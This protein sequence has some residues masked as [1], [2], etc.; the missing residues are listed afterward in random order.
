MEQAKITPDDRILE[1][2]PGTGV[3]TWSLVQTKA[4]V[5]L[6]EIEAAFIN[7]LSER[8]LDCDQTQI[9]QADA[10]AWIEDDEN[11]N[12]TQFNK[13][14]SNIP[15]S[16]SSPLITNLAFH[17]FRLQS[18]VLLVQKEVAERVVAPVNSSQRGVLSLLAQEV[19]DVK[20]AGIVPATAF[21]PKP[22]ID[23]AILVLS[24]KQDGNLH[25]LE[26]FFLF[27]KI[28]FKHRRK[29]VYNN[30]RS[31]LKSSCEDLP[32]NIQL[33]MKKRPQNLTG[34]DIRNLM[35]QVQ[36]K[37]GDTHV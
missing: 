36:M 8:L 5:I 16:I 7:L 12:S 17:A 19:F 11:W 35:E 9:I 26:Q 6:V 27:L 23:S 22:S 25:N 24:T 13:C 4:Y 14:V 29:T 28:L 33:L 18:A 1:I 15:Y 3:L 30:I 2:G 34:G 31:L 10:L 32:G 37:S 21:W 20:I